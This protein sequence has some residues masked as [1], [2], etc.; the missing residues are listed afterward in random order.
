MEVQPSHEQPG[1]QNRCER[2]MIFI[3]YAAINHRRHHIRHFLESLPYNESS[4]LSASTLRWKLFLP[5]HNNSRDLRTA[6]KNAHG[7]GLH[8]ETIRLVQ[9]T[10]CLICTVKYLTKWSALNPHTYNEKISSLHLLITQDYSTTQRPKIVTLSS[11]NPFRSLA[12]KQDLQMLISIRL[13]N[14]EHKDTRAPLRNARHATTTKPKRVDSRFISMREIAKIL[15][16]VL[17]NTELA[18]AYIICMI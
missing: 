2:K 11:G 14:I 3:V 18:R 8:A 13:P 1:L 9:L 12:P 6:H 5:T 15:I 7:M 4:K 17:G 16:L 10:V